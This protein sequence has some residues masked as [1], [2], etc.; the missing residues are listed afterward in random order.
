M[1][2]RKSI[3]DW[4][5]DDRPREK[6]IAN[7][8]ASLS[9]V[10]LLAIIIGS[11]TKNISAVDVARQILAD[12]ENKVDNLYK[13]SYSDLLKYEGI[14]E[15]K[16]VKVA[17]AVELSRRRKAEPVV[18]VTRSED[19]FKAVVSR[20]TDSPREMAFAIYLNNANKII[21]IEN[22]S[23]GGIDRTVMDS[24]LVLGE[25][26]RLN[27]TALAVVHN[28]P[29]GRIVPS[30]ED[31]ALT[32]KFN[33]ACSLLGIR[34]VDHLIISSNGRDYYSYHDMGRV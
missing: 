34:F 15:A 33:D 10:E 23:R 31:D 2:E 22:L 18:Q 30:A 13:L 17:A 20:V 29:S 27:A 7:G 6:L 14:G 21:R 28:H 19:I 5:E 25:A 32:R 26:L 24:R 1:I 4:A 9:D 12:C 16:A 8:P 11:G 3:K